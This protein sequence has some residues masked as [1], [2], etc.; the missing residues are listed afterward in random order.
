WPAGANGAGLAPQPDPQVTVGSWIA[1][2]TY[3]RFQAA[4]AGKPPATAGHRCHWYR[5]LRVGVPQPHP[6]LPG[7]R[8]LVVTL[9]TPVRAKTAMMPNGDSA[10]VNV[11]LVSPYVVN[12]I[13]RVFYV[14]N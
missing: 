10:V 12:V 4:L 11:A 5:I 3:E 9:A 6:I 1:D 13:P 8:R 7:S 2:V 14:R